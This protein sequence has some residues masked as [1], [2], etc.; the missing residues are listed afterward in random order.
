MM[1]VA[2]GIDLVEV[3]RLRS[4]TPAIKARFVSRVFTTQEIED[5][6]GRDDRLAARFAIKEATVKALGCGIGEVGWQDIETQLDE[7][8]KPVLR[9]YGA[10]AQM[11]ER[12]NWRSW[13]VSISHTRNLAAACVTALVEKR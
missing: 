4:I 8:G 12:M 9:L 10:A 6:G 2:C 1:E 7:N 11:A 5:S 13:S 3:E